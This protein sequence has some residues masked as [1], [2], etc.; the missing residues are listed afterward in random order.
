MIAPPDAQSN[1]PTSGRGCSCVTLAARLADACAGADGAQQKFSPSA[2]PHAAV[3]SCDSHRARHRRQASA[4]SWIVGVSP[5]G[6]FGGPEGRHDIPRVRRSG[7]DEPSCGRSCAHPVWMSSKRCR[8]GSSA[9]TGRSSTRQSIWAP[10]PGRRMLA[11]S[12][13]R[14]L[15]DVVHVE[16]VDGRSLV[17]A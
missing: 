4:R 3:H 2:R 15:E 9:P 8:T 11:E 14:P 10:R 17:N 6:E 1:K 16:I 5:Q 13:V 7:I 12:A